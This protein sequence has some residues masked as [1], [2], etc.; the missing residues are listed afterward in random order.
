M[1]IWLDNITDEQIK[2]FIKSKERC[3]EIVIERYNDLIKISTKEISANE[4][5]DDRKRRYVY[6]AYGKGY[7]H[8]N[9][10]I[11]N[12]FNKNDMEWFNIVNQANIG[13]K[14][15]GLTY[16]EAFEQAYESAMITDKNIKNR[17]ISNQILELK[18]IQTQN[19]EKLNQDLKNMH[20][21]INNIRIKAEKGGEIKRVDESL[22]VKDFLS[23]MPA[24]ERL[25]WLKENGFTKDN[26]VSV[27]G[28]E[29]NN[30]LVI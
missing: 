17:L 30:S 27:S 23:K 12:P 28:A 1:K 11:L 16:C 7:I 14:I 24:N 19:D 15:D 2:K 10:F 8:K 25:D 3:D 29:E 6:N 26:L 13:E 18:K 9:K 21:V 5:Y 22:I 20:K 4:E